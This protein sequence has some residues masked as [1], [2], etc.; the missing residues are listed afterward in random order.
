MIRQTTLLP[1]RAYHRH[2]IFYFT[3]SYLIE[4]LKSF[5]RKYKVLR[6][7]ILVVICDKIRQMW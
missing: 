5:I 7:C 2:Y 6:E 4:I 1:Y 3:I